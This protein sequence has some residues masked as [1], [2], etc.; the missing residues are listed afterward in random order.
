[1]STDDPASY[2]LADYDFTFPP[3]L[4]AHRT[5]GKGNTRIL[6]CPRSGGAPHIIASAE[7]VNLFKAG[8]CLVVNNTKVIPARLFGHT[9]NGGE[10]EVLLVQALPPA[11][12]GEAR[13]EAWV[14]PGRAFKV[15]KELTIA[16]LP[17]TVESVNA[18]GPRVLRFAANPAEFQQVIEREGHIPLPPY[19]ER[20]DDAS[21]REAYQ[22]VFAKHA[23]AVAAPTASLHFSPEMLAAL[24]DQGVHIA[25][26]T[27]HVGPGTFANISCEDDFRAH[28]MH[29]EVYNISETDANIINQCK[30]QGGRIVCVGTTST[31]V[32]ETVADSNGIVH[33]DTGVTHAFIYPGI[34][35]KV[36]DGLL[37]NFHWP[38][39]SLILL[40]SA[41]YGKDRTLS[42]YRQAVE[43]RLNLFSYGDGM[44]IL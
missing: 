6:H 9:A 36:V 42:A 31:R 20:P 4:I 10:V 28:Q 2:R 41:F 1:M 43:N 35:F 12:T 24:R 15:G 3:E 37:T 11:S 32:L 27:L 26:V 14:R 34:A 13:W 25:E 17:C 33:A 40:V 38:K 22:T 7:I 21:D 5:A 44:F 16:T 29:G 23:G 19:I 18:D 8:D 30:A 39:S